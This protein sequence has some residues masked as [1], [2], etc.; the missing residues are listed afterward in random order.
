MMTRKI[1]DERALKAKC[2]DFLLKEHSEVHPYSGE[3][4]LINELHFRDG[5]RRADLVEVNGCLNVYEIKSDLDN[6]DRLA[7]QLADYKNSFDTITVVATFKHIHALKTLCP[8]HIGLLLFD[9]GGLRRLRKPMRYKKFDGFSLAALLTQQ[10]VNNLVKSLQI[11]GR[12]N[13]SL[14]EKRMCIAT[15]IEMESL[16]NDVLCQLKQRYKTNYSRFLS[17]RGQHTMP[18]DVELL[19]TGFGF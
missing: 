9:D 13:M 16:K 14:T 2:I 11:K 8:R 10:E 6:L 4:V 18:D 3:Y 17:Y 7:D 12:S 1:I 15:K 19:S 5:K